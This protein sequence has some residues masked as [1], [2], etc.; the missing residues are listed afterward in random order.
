MIS[1]RFYYEILID[2]WG[3]VKM[4]VNQLEHSMETEIQV[5]SFFE[6]MTF[7][8]RHI[9]VT[10]VLFVAF[11]IEAWEMTIIVFLTEDIAST[12]NLTNVQSGSII[13]SLF[14]GMLPGAYIW[15]IFADKYG[16]R[17][18]IILSHVVFGIMTLI[19]AYSLNYEMLYVT[20]ILAGFGL[21]GTLACCFPY[22]LEMLPLKNR[23]SGGVLLS[24]GFPIGS[25]IAVGVTAMFIDSAMF[26]IEGWRM[27][28]TI[29]ALAGLW[30]FV[31]AKLPES[32][33][34]LA[35]K[36]DQVEAKKVINYLSMGEQNVDKKTT[37]VVEDV[38]RGNFFEI[39]KKRLLKVTILASIVNFVFNFGYWGLF[40]WLPTLL[41]KKG[42]SM[43]DTLGFVA[44]SALFQ[45]PGYLASSYLTNKYG[46]KKVMF[47]FVSLSILF[48]FAFAFSSTTFQLYTFYFI[49]GFFLLGAFGI[50]NPWMGEIYPTNVRT[51]GYSWGQSVQRWQN[52]FAPI[53]IGYLLSIGWG[54]ESIVTFVMMFLVV[55]LV[56]IPFIKETKD[57]I[58]H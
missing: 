12:L 18:T 20:R 51:I 42:L 28:L 23:G 39:F 29:S 54:F 44:L 55:T 11:A 46:R 37:L 10:A 30:G 27:V 21:A 24:A 25:I 5:G 19:S 36:G 33:Y 3:V 41:A 47:A 2:R 13:G 53:I 48:G 34:W 16:R 56:T 15:G 35:G 6:K 50:W 45:I 8:R 32:P 57:E 43:S 14:L 17:R 52:I 31:I 49:L 38:K 1:Y 22:F 58:L 26:G 7:T 4:S 9:F 40:T